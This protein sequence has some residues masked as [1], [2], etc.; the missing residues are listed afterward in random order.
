MFFSRFIY[1]VRVLFV[2]SSV[3]VGSKVMVVIGVVCIVFYRRMILF[4][5]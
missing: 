4:F 5:R 2:V 1:L 3:E